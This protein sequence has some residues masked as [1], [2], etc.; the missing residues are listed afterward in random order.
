MKAIN[1]AQDEYE[2]T[3]RANLEAARLRAIDMKFATGVA[4][5]ARFSQSQ[6]MSR[7]LPVNKAS[8]PEQQEQD[9]DFNQAAPQ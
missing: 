8:I 5:S 4:G 6:H 1:E 2:M 7:R 3:Q 9:Q